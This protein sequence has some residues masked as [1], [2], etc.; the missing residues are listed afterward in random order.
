MWD[1]THMC[2]PTNLPLTCESASLWVSRPLC[3]PWTSPTHSLLPNGLFTLSA[4][5]PWV[6]RTPS[7]GTMCQPARTSMGTPYVHVHRNLAPHHYLAPLAIFLCWAFLS[8]IFIC[9]PFRLSL[10]PLDRDH[11]HLTTFATHHHGLWYHLLGRINTL[12]SFLE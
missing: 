11:E 5:H 3:G 8:K 12:G 7:M 9:G 10:S 4:R 6:S 1:F 2:N